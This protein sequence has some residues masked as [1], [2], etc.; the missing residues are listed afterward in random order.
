MFHFYHHNAYQCTCKYWC[1]NSKY[2]FEIVFCPC[3]ILVL[4]SS[5][6]P[7][8]SDKQMYILEFPVSHGIRCPAKFRYHRNACQCGNERYHCNC[9]YCCL[10]SKYIMQI[11]LRPRNILGPPTS[12]SAHHTPDPYMPMYILGHPESNRTA[13]DVVILLNRSQPTTTRTT[14]SR[15]VLLFLPEDPD[16]D[17]LKCG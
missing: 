6:H 2:M 3:N 15:S 16:D 17:R 4:Y 10:N 9:R 11:V 5:A 14:T 8:P 13:E 7:S 12:S 1:S